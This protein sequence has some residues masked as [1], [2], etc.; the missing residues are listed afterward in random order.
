MRSSYEMVAT[1][2][3]GTE[4]ILSQEE[5]RNAAAKLENSNGIAVRTHWLAHDKA[6]DIF[7]S[8]IAAENLRS[9]QTF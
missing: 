4:S 1:I 8:G 2:V 7:C 3:A 6:V 9:Q 5:I